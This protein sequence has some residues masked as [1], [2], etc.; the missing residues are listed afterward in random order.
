[1]GRK[2]E[3]PFAKNQPGNDEAD[4]RRRLRDAGHRLSWPEPD[5]GRRILA[6]VRKAVPEPDGGRAATSQAHDSYRRLRLGGIG[7]RLVDIPF[8]IRYDGLENSRGTTGHDADGT[9]SLELNMNHNQQYQDDIEVTE[10][11][12]S[13]I[14]AAMEDAYDMELPKPEAR[15]L[16]RLFKELARWQRTDDATSSARGLDEMIR[17]LR[18]VFWS[19]KDSDASGNPAHAEAYKLLALVPLKDKQRITNGIREIIIEYRPIE[20]DPVVAEKA[21]QLIKDRYSVELTEL[22][23]EQTIQYLTRKLWVEE[24]L[25]SSLEDCVDDLLHGRDQHS[26][27]RN[28]L[29]WAIKKLES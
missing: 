4:N 16:T 15:R 10:E 2:P 5:T 18:D 23:L 26:G 20:N 22:Q 7:G 19:D 17:G 9:Y 8:L 28:A 24:G 1:V 25:G 11:E 29:D 6:K 14:M 12:V 21:A 3:H 27:V 13:R